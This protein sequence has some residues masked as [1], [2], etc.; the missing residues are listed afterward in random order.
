M[1]LKKKKHKTDKSDQYV[2]NLGIIENIMVS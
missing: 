1:I 2:I